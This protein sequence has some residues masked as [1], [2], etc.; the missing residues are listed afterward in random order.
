MSNF[1]ANGVKQREYFIDMVDELSKL[2]RIVRKLE[3]FL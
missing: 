3:R 2:E 1:K